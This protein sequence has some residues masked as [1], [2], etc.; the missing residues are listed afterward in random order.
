MVLKT[1][2]P[3]YGT[4]GSNPT[5][6]ARYDGSLYALTLHSDLTKRLLQK[7]A[8]RVYIESFNK[9]LEYLKHEKPGVQSQISN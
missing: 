4:V 1:I 7:I 6:S 2:V 8:A 5:P 3:V 9:L